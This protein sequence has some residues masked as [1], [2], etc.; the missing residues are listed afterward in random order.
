M[1]YVQIKNEFP[2]MVTLYQQTEHGIEQLAE[3]QPQEKFNLPVPNYVDKTPLKIG[4]GLE[5]IS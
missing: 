3:L 4:I 1:F 5:C 2:I